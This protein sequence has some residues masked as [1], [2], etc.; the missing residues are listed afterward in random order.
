LAGSGSDVI[1]VPSWDLPEETEETHDKSV[2]ITDI[3]A[4]TPIKTQ[5]RDQW[6]ALV[7]LQVP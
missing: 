7:N 2:R 3:P 1:E 5:E 4:K 6:R